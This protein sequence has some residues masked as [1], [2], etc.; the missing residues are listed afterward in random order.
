MV[1]FF[2]ER[3]FIWV[4][5]KLIDIFWIEKIDSHT[6]YLGQPFKGVVYEQTISYGGFVFFPF[7][8]FTKL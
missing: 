1:C 4:W 2:Q 3:Y 8:I 7:S 5:K 6:I